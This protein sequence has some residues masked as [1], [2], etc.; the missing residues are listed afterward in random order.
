MLWIAT[1]SAKYTSPRLRYKELW[2][3]AG[4]AVKDVLLYLIKFAAEMKE[5]YLNDVK[6]LSAHRYLLLY[7][8]NMK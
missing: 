2:E 3:R 1:A 7:Y 6:M 5:T 4:I 8:Y